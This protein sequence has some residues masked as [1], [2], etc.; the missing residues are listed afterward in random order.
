MHA[1]RVKLVTCTILLFLTGS[2]FAEKLGYALSGGGARG[3]AHIGVLKVLEEEGLKPDCI[4]GSSIGAIIGGMY[5][6]GFSA[7]EIESICLSVDW[8]NLTRDEHTRKQLYIGQ[9]R[10]APYGNL[11][12]ELNDKWVPQLPSSVF[13][14]NQINLDLF[15]ILAPASQ[16]S[17]FSK[18]PIPFACNATNLINGDP[19]TFT[20]GSLMQALRAS[21]SIPSLVEP[22]EIEGEI[23]IDG[24][25]SQN[26]PFN[27]LQELGATKMIG[28]KV[29]S[30]LKSN[31]QL[32]NLVNILDQTINIGITR[33]L[34][35]QLSNCDLMIEPNLENYSANDFEQISAIIAAGELSARANIS[36]I[37][38]FKASLM[39]QSALASNSFHKNL[40]SF[41]VIDIQVTGNKHVSAAKVREYLNLKVAHTY[42]TEDIYA[43]CQG[44]WNSQVFSTIYPVLEK[45]ANDDYVLH[46]HVSELDRK[47]IALN[48]TYN[49]E[50]K[51]VAGMVFGLNNYLLKNSKLLTEVKLGGKNELNVDYVKNFGEQWGAYYRIFPYINEKTIYNYSD[52]HKT[53]SVNSLELGFTSGVGIFAKDIATAELFI[54]SDQTRLYNEISETP[55]LPKRN[56]ISG[57]G[58]KAYHESLDDYIFPM[59]GFRVINKF[60]FARNVEISDYIYSRFQGKAEM[61]VP[62]SKWLSMDVCLA[63]GSYFNSPD[64]KYLEPFYFGGDGGFL[65]YSR[66]EMSAPHYQ[67]SSLGFTSTPWKR[68][69]VNAD[70]QALR[71]SDSDIWG[72]QKDW[73]YC[74]VTGIGYKNTF[75]P[76]RLNLSMNE[77]KDFKSYLSVGY[78]F[79]IFHF[80]RK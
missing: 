79:D 41:R 78:D 74:L 9:K 60:N 58:V 59:R 33:N 18:L 39:K 69:V 43:A 46:I 56:V 51:L 11:V 28:V 66:Y 2:L 52:H 17:D 5:A 12:L 20:K 22:F 25:V 61:Y 3:F 35:E 64:N 45:T 57:F 37:R 14:G 1:L 26:L 6:M 42:S 71:F 77:K 70:V 8:A 63:Y 36:E 10:W 55:L 80:S 7:E 50:D 29:N 21:M 38:A 53:N 13:V 76:I 62:L 24:G 47:H 67:I 48:F 68:W 32:N 65:G 4:S 31:E 54:F 15:K 23:Y 34:N 44:A 49:S 40:F 72:V 30:S 75:M 16:V 19:T 73:E 27:L